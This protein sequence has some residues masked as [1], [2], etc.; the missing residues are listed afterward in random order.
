MIYALEIR[1]FGKKEEFM[2]RNLRHRGGFTL[3]ELLIVAIILAILAAV[4]IPQFGESAQ[5]TKISV[6]KA[7]LH[8]VRSQ[9]ELYRLQHNTT[10]PLL[11]T[12][13]DQMTKKTDADG[14]V[15]A[16]GKYGPYLLTVPVNPM[17]NTSSLSATQD[18]SGGWTYVQGTGVFQANDGDAA[19][20]PL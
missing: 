20:D 3:V 17:D 18:G 10:Y 4:V 19:T 12:W 7:S 6:V 16:S 13:S 9:L 1:T 11:A 8:T 2:S 14:T 15:N 5:D